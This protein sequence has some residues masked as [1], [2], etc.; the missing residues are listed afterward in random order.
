MPRIEQL[1]QDPNVKQC[2]AV[3]YA[4]HRQ[5]RGRFPDNCVQVV[6]SREAALEGAKPEEHFYPAV[7]CGPS[8]SSEGVMLFYLVQW[9]SA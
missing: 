6:A 5:K 4:P 7:V 1:L 9:L 2:F 3:I 8:R